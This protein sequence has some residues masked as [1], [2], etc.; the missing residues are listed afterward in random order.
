MAAD[1]TTSDTSPGS[2]DASLLVEIAQGDEAAMAQFYSR[3][4]KRV[5]SVA[6]RVLRDPS[7]AEDVLQ[8]IFMQIWRKPETFNVTRGS[9]E[10]WL[11]VIARN[12]AIDVIRGR[13]PT[14]LID[15]LPL[16]SSQDLAAEV[17]HSVTL[18]RVKQLV[19]TLPQEQR[20]ALNLAFFQGLTHSEIAQKTGDPLGTVKTRIRIGLQTLGKLFG[21][22]HK[23]TMS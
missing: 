22:D 21:D 7:S 14:E 8:D 2:L 5:Y 9:L 10:G 4:A 19:A 6:L 18:E 15:D 11:S 23:P 17:E 12:R 3:H 16:P 20:Q 13:K 1:H